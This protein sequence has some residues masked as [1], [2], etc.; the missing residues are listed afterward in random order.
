M[1]R[2]IS[3][4]KHQNV[5]AK[6]WHLDVGVFFCESKGAFK[7]SITANSSKLLISTRQN[8]LSL[9]NQFARFYLTLPTIARFQFAWT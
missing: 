2:H 6:H 8:Y 7:S 4:E 3:P 1:T 9:Q 5:T